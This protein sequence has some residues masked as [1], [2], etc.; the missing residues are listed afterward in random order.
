MNTYQYYPSVLLV[1]MYDAQLINIYILVLYDARV[2]IFPWNKISICEALCV[3]EDKT[4]QN[5]DHMH[6]LCYLL[7]LVSFYLSDG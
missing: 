5:R 6:A 2:Y 3:N 1:C 4:R 7:C